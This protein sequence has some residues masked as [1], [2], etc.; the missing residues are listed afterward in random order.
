MRTLT[1]AIPEAV[2]ESGEEARLIKAALGGDLAAFD[3]LMRRHERTVLLT[4]LR[5]LGQLED[6]QDASQEVFLRLYRNLGK[7]EAVNLRAWLYRVTVNA[8][9][10]LRRARPA[11]LATVE[12]AGDVPAAGA[13]PLME[14]AEAER[15]R[16]VELS[17]RWLAARER[18]AIVLHDMEGLSTAE[19]ARAMGANE[20]TVRSH[21][22]QARI[23]MREFL[24]R[25]FRRRV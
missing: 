21:L 4:S 11:L 13:D 20:A 2:G 1:L 24:E 12:D 15:R 23:K 8:C 25:Y 6:A 14:V 9:H 7:V 18:E 16:A 22:S 17:L 5:L 3:T 19:T 10:D